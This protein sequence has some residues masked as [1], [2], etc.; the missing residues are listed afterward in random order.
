MIV[1]MT[2]AF[3]FITATFSLKM[4]SGRY[5]TDIFASQTTIHRLQEVMFN[6]PE[7]KSAPHVTR[8]A[9]VHSGIKI[10][11]REWRA[12]EDGGVSMGLLA[13]GKR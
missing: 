13:G 10:S 7:P 11:Q 4:W 12:K 9:S 1:D 6:R 2:D 5:H 8:K 3:Y